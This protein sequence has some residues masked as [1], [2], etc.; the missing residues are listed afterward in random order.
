[1]FYDDN[2]RRDANE[3]TT[4]KF[5]AKEEVNGHKDRVLKDVFDNTASGNSSNYTENNKIAHNKPNYGEEKTYSINQ[6]IGTESEVN[7][8]KKTSFSEDL[9]EESKY[10]KTTSKY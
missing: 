2:N 5:I 10:S 3:K 8:P 6:N 1:M 7:K 9:E 4:K